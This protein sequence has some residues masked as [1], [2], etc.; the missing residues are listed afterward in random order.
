VKKINQ[1][2]VDFQV[3]DTVTSAG[4]TESDNDGKLL[5]A[6]VIHMHEKVSRPEMLVGATYKIKTPLSEHARYVTIND[7]VLNPSTDHELRLP[8]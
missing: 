3:V 1:P 2:R 6:D 8:F 7:I 5:E 4:E